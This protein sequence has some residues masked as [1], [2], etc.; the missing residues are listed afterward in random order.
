MET[1]NKIILLI[2]WSLLFTFAVEMIAPIY[3]IFVKNIGENILSGEVAYA[4]YGSI[5]NITTVYGK[6]SQ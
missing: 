6:I 4:I 1:K 3:A 2:A 5:F